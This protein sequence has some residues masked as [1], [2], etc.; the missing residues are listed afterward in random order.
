MICGKMSALKANED[1]K[2]KIANLKGKLSVNEKKSYFISL[3]IFIQTQENMM[4]MG[5]YSDT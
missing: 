1:P 3:S 4:L 5:M 2:N